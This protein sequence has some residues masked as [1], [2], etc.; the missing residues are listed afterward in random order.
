MSNNI[1]LLLSKTTV[2]PMCKDPFCDVFF[3]EHSQEASFTGLE[4]V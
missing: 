4:L 3:I 1:P 2:H